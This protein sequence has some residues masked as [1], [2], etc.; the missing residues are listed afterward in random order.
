MIR[1][2]GDSL[3]VEFIMY[4]V[5][6]A[7]YFKKLIID[8]IH[9]IHLGGGS[10]VSLRQ[11]KSVVWIFLWSKLRHIHIQS[12]WKQKYLMKFK[13][14]FYNLY[15]YYL[16]CLFTTERYFTFNCFYCKFKILKK[17]YL[18]SFIYL[19]YIIP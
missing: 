3:E 19:T 17:S 6:N 16:R 14:L 8:T 10:L 2:T 9:P 4:I 15:I 7:S 13:L 12:I 1:F 5:K 18:T 11:G